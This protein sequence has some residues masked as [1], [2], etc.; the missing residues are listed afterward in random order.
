MERLKVKRTSR[1]RQ[2][3]RLVGEAKTALSS[4]PNDRKTVESLLERLRVNLE[5]LKEINSEF[6]GHLKDDELEVE[7]EMALEYEENSIKEMSNLRVALQELTSVSTPATQVAA[8]TN[9]AL[10]GTTLTRRRFM[11]ITL[12]PCTRLPKLQLMRFRG[13]LSEWLPFWEQF[14][15]TVHNN[16]N[17]SQPEKFFYLRSLLD[18][19]AAAAI[20]GLQASEVCYNDAIEILMERF[21]DKRPQT[22]INVPRTSQFGHNVQ[23]L[24]GCPLDILWMS[25]NIHKYPLFIQC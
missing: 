23:I 3:T 2:A 24:D 20:S 1:R 11:A 6:E 16:S 4:T 5:E 9:V 12:G 15:G 18:G 7:H 10:L 8:P 17:L 22:T 21:G 13:D 25:Q 19:A 14:K